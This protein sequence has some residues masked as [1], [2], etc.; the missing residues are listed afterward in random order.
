MEIDSFLENLEKVKA[1]NKAPENK[2]KNVLRKNI[3]ATTIKQEHTI[4]QIENIRATTIKQEHTKDKI[5]GTIEEVLNRVME[6]VSLSDDVKEEKPKD[7]IESIIEDVINTVIE[8][9]EN[10]A[11][12]KYLR[13]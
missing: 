7:Q 6:K 3:R 13:V 11:H 1:M 5:E 8:K 4:E 12:E 2:L 10:E 9:V